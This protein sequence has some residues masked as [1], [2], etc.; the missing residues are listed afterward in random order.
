MTEFVSRS[1]AL[2]SLPLALLSEYKTS[3]MDRLSPGTSLGAPGDKLH[4][5]LPQALFSE[6]PET[7]TQAFSWHPF[8]CLKISMRTAISAHAWSLT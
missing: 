3:Y 5:S 8:R 2:T 4:K 1:P 7:D 6:Y